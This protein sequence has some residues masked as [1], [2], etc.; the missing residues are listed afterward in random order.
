[1]KKKFGLIIFIAWAI[2]ILQ[3]AVEQP[4]EHE[5]IKTP[6]WISIALPTILIVAPLVATYLVFLINTLTE[7][8][9]ITL[10]IIYTI[11]I[12]DL[13]GEGLLMGGNRDC[14]VHTIHDIKLDLILGMILAYPPWILF[15]LVK[16]T[17][18]YFVK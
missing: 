18:K 8:T 15:L 2:L 10:L 4:G 7:K 11:F 3:L 6:L 5:E 1:M 17:K 16:K 12:I 14:L 9:I 13:I